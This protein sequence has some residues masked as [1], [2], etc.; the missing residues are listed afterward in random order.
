M[1]CTEE[2]LY[3]ACINFC[4]SFFMLLCE[5]DKLRNEWCRE[6]EYDIRM[7]FANDKLEAAYS[8]LFKAVENWENES[9]GV[10]GRNQ[11][12]LVLKENKEIKDD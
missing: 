9:N 7:R 11:Y 4:Q 5:K 2:Q 8:K 3:H 12:R 6:D 1:S 10:I